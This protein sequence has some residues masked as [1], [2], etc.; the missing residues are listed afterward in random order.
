MH[1]A[2]APLLTPQALGTA[3]EDSRRAAIGIICG[4]I[5]A[6]G[7]TDDQMKRTTQPKGYEV[8]T[9]DPMQLLD[10]GIRALGWE[11]QDWRDQLEVRVYRNYET[12]CRD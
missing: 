3:S 5:R 1:A 10:S 12:W 2:A 8:Y 7:E 6:D 9:W 11:I 4:C